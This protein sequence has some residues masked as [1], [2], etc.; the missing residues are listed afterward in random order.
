MQKHAEIGTKNKKSKE[1]KGNQE[2]LSYIILG[3]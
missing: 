2:Y 1:K 3:V